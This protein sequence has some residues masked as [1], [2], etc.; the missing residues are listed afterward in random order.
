MD[1]ETH[2]GLQGSDEWAAGRDTRY[3]A[4]DLAAAAGDS[5]YKTRDKL[6]RQLATGEV[7]EIT[8]EQ[9]RRFDDGHRFEKLARP[10]AEKLLG[11]ELYPSVL[12]V[13][14]AG[15]K[16]PL[17]TSLDGKVMADTE[18]WEHKSLNAEL[19]ASLDMGIIPSTYHWQMEQGQMINGATKTLFTA[20][21]WKKAG[22][23][24]V[25]AEIDEEPG[26]IYGRAED[27]DGTLVWY[28]LVDIKHVWYESN[29]VL[30][31]KIIPTWKQA[32]EDAANYRPVEVIPAAVGA[33]VK[34]LPAVM[35][36]VSGTVSI[37]DNFD[38]F[39]I[40]LRDFIDNRLV[41][42]PKTDQD[43]ADLGEQIASL[44]KAE[45][46]LD[47][48]EA[49]M[50]AQVASVDAMKRTKDMLHN[51]TRDNRLVA[52]KLLKDE[53]VR[54][55]TEIVTNAQ[56][57]LL[58]YVDALHRRI[59][60]N[61]IQINKGVFVEAIKGLSSIDSMNSEVSAALANA[62]IEA[63][64]V[65]DRVDANRKTMEGLGDATL[66]PDF[67]HVCTKAL[68]DFAALVA[69]RVSQRKEAEEKRI[70][71]EREKIRKEEQERADREAAAKVEADRK[72]A[73]ATNTPPAVSDPAPVTTPA[74]VQQ[75]VE[76]TRTP[77]GAVIRAVSPEAVVVALAPSRIQA[78]AARM[79]TYTS[80]EIK[81]VE[82]CCERIE[83]M[84]QD[85]A[86]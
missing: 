11:Q 3:N 56:N 86:A 85:D 36:K 16:R 19:A 37:V 24:V 33:A 71:A 14:V 65:A 12:S 51:M 10:L 20:S 45:A 39:E 42:E 63:S 18:N 28:V 76:Q 27:E 58:E 46:A 4:S 50:I 1:Y 8:P 68:D 83:A 41:R 26:E 54:R 30:R 13:A 35:V 48:A 38:L 15:L 62:K 73:E 55:K 84:R 70:A 52:E 23:E 64:A 32:E 22:G 21:K 59:G 77:M 17:G 78:I 40:A 49:Q 79:S 29:P 9:Q 6:I 74:P 75:P 82:H 2:E 43:F 81:I 53:K 34:N 5:P 72:A 25:K 31:A 69:M 61:C 60:V 57:A 66:F 47:A 7:D 44:K 80:D 67:A